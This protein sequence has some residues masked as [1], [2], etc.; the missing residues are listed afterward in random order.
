MTI[1][2]P[3]STAALVLIYGVLMAVSVMFSRALERLGVPILLLFL[4]L[5]I[6]AGSEGIGGIEFDN[7]LF[8]FRVG[9]VALILILFD[10]GLNTPW[11][12]IKG[13][14]PPAA[15]LATV[16]VVGAAGLTACAARLLGLNWSEALL[17][18]AVVSST[19]AA[20]VFAVLRGSRLNL[21]K[22]ASLT[23][24]LESGLNDPMAVI[25]TTAFAQMAISG[26]A[27]GW[28]L[29]WQAP[30]Q[31]VIGALIGLAI[32]WTGLALLTRLRLR[33]GGLY[34]VL[35]L[36]LALIAFGAATMA[37][38]SGFLAVYTAGV[39]IGNSRTPYRHGLR[40]IHDA[41]AWLGQISMFLILGM[42]VFPSRLV[43]AAPIGIAIALFLAFI[44]RPLA[45][46][47]CLAPFRYERKHMAFI[48]WAG[49]RG[50]V[51]IILATIPVLAEA[52]G[53]H[54]IFNIV[55]FVVVVNA[56]LP[57]ATLRWA[58]RAFGL[59]RTIPPD[60]PAALEINS[61]QLLE[62]EILLFF[63]DESLAVA[64]APLAKLPM[65]SGSAVLLVMRGR[66]L[67][68]ARGAT[69]LK[70]GDH[71]YLFC[72]EADRPLIE[73]LFGR[74]TT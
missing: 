19:D 26:A 7:Y 64:G 4:L 40:R 34:P 28:G 51:P 29:L 31:L 21:E 14:I 65:P 58:A 53:A 57:G 6:A 32:G 71:V 56:I 66:E 18:G 9:A 11:R 22:R 62:G 73:L 68:A 13:G 17:L 10:G 25:L 37:Y 41:L 72:R 5:G 63:I 61:T 50:A 54:K 39:V 42:L 2:E 52:P 24:E 44:A 36:G 60:P 16:G 27:P 59:E 12:S 8:A 48:G 1:S 30:L 70:P 33:A 15:S 35:T 74:P 46:L 47:I 23:L 3:F 38:G 69:V 45:T 67:I 20:A 49:L 43:D 55:F